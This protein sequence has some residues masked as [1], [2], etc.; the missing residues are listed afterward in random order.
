VKL[1]YTLGPR[2]GGDVVLLMPTTIKQKSELM[3]LPIMLEDMMSCLEMG[4]EIEKMW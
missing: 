4:G 3:R 2:R 1:N